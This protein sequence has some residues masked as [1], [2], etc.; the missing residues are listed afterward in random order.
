M[1]S[2][3]PDRKLP[4]SLIRAL[5]AEEKFPLRTLD[6]IREVR[7]YL[8]RLENDALCDSR[9][10]GASISEIA[11]VMH[12]TRQSVYNRLKSIAERKAEEVRKAEEAAVVVPDLEEKK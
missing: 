8:E 6:A 1:V 5:E 11:D 9:E 3:M 7:E 4:R 12:M 10:A 2:S